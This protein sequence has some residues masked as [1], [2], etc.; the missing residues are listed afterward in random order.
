MT[1]APMGTLQEQAVKR[2]YATRKKHGFFRGWIGYFAY[3]RLIISG[4]ADI[5]MMAFTHPPE[6]K[7]LWADSGH[8]VALFLDGQPWAFVD[9]DKNHG[10]SKGI[11]RP[12]I[13]NTWDQ[14]L[15]EKT[16]NAG[17]ASP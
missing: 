8:S 11:L 15:F 4:E 12:T 6:L 1:L 10:Y 13:G 14:M 9:E 16:F 17:G 5:R 3:R 2:S 7:L